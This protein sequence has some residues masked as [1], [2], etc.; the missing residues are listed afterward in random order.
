MTALSLPSAEF[1]EEV[2]AALQSAG[3]DP[4][5]APGSEAATGPE[6]TQRRGAA[7]WDS[8]QSGSN[9][10]PSAYTRKQKE[11][12]DRWVRD[13]IMP[14]SP[15]LILPLQLFQCTVHWNNAI[16]SLLLC[17][18]CVY[19]RMRVLQSC[20]DFTWWVYTPTKRFEDLRVWYC[21]KD[22]A[23]HF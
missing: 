13:R 14:V 2:N 20:E 23:V 6:V 11:A 5:E 22:A 1:I 8:E 17:C 10:S 12:V 9:R 7:D 19:V 18:V 21:T 3:G 4:S 15:H 16:L